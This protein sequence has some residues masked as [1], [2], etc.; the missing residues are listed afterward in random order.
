MKEV[1]WMALKLPAV[2]VISVM[3]LSGCS[4]IKQEGLKIQSSEKQ[5]LLFSNEENIGAEE[6]YYDALLDLRGKFPEE[7]KNIRI[8]HQSSIRINNDL[9]E[10]QSYPALIMIENNKIL[11]K[12]EGSVPKQQ[13][14]EQ[15]Q[16]T[17]S[18][19]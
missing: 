11:T 5:V 2:L 15:L 16:R 9:I 3:L 6:R 10:L 12:I 7:L 14:I 13:I 1:T 17:L 8:V 18:V 19:K 4:I